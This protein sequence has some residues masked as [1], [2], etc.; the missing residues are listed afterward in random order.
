MIGKWSTMSLYQ[1]H[2][3]PRMWNPSPVARLMGNSLPKLGRRTSLNAALLSL[4][5][6]PAD[7]ASKMSIWNFALT[8]Q[9]TCPGSDGVLNAD[10]KI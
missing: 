1:Y 4:R 7:P 3:A 9:S 8:S 5:Q 6:R 2:S 10:E